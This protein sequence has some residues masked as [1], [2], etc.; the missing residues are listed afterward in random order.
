M[1]TPRGSARRTNGSSVFWRTTRAPKAPNRASLIAEIIPSRSVLDRPL[2]DPRLT[3]Q[4]LHGAIGGATVHPS[5]GGAQEDR[6][7]GPFAYIQVERPSGTP[8]ERDNRLLAALAQHSQ[9]AM[10]AVDV[11]VVNIGAKRL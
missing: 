2:G 9:R 8:G 1:R 5:L 11:Q 10:T 6:P 4:P 3:R 7:G